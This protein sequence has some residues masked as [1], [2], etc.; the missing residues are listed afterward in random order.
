MPLVPLGDLIGPA[1]H[2]P[3]PESQDESTDGF[4][5][6]VDH[7]QHA[8]SFVDAAPRGS[9]CWPPMLSRLCGIGQSGMAIELEG[10]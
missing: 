3:I 6:R 7:T 1:Q 5:K 10:C 4:D 2:D 9:R 8:P